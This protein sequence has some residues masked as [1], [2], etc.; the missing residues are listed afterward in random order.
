M[1]VREVHKRTAW[2]SDPCEFTYRDNQ[3]LV[4][5]DFA[6]IY[7]IIGDELRCDCDVAPMLE[8]TPDYD[9]LVC[10]HCRKRYMFIDVRR[11]ISK[12]METQELEM[13]KARAYQITEKIEKVHDDS[14]D[15]SEEQSEGPT[16]KFNLHDYLLYKDMEEEKAMQKQRELEE[17]R[18]FDT[19]I[20]I[21]GENMSDED[22]L[23]D[24][25]AMLLAIKNGELPKEAVR[26]NNDFDEDDD[27]NEDMGEDEYETTK[28]EME[29]KNNELNE[30]IKRMSEDDDDEDI[31]EVSDDDMYEEILSLQN[32]SHE[33]EDDEEFNSNEEESHSV[34]IDVV[35]KEYIETPDSNEQIEYPDCEI[36]ED[37]THILSKP[38]KSAYIKRALRKSI[39]EEVKNEPVPIKSVSFQ[40]LLDEDISDDTEIEP[41]NHEEVELKEQISNLLV[42]YIAMKGIDTSELDLAIDLSFTTQMNQEKDSDGEI[43]I[44]NN[45]SSETEE[46]VVVEEIKIGALAEE[47]RD[48]QYASYMSTLIEKY[49]QDGDE[50]EEVEELVQD[51]E[52]LEE[53]LQKMYSEL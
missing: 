34:T 5:L 22:D 20:D 52:D 31:V 45:K 38:V 9:K 41:V 14:M 4:A 50:E 3:E 33:S 43:I 2:I 42:K 25:V 21:Q 26:V 40:M 44:I 18:N 51:D 27:Y 53:E 46:P 28:L 11:R 24:E 17:E 6:Y 35:Q 49:G 37:H 19:I 36:E 13:S 47:E 23:L 7:R 15:V 16:F 48:D 10:P 29:R 32:R 39:K 8:Y 1:R 12:E 30:L